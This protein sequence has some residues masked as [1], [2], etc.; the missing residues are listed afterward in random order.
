MLVTVIECALRPCD[1]FLDNTEQGLHHRL[2]NPYGPTPFILIV[3][4]GRF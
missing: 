1:W 3:F 2:L 4:A